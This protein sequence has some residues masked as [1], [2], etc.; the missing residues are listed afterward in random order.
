VKKPD[1]EPKDGKVATG[2][3]IGIAIP[4]AVPDAPGQ[5]HVLEEKMN[6]IHPC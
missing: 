3:G 4:H 2:I 5:F 6:I 1:V